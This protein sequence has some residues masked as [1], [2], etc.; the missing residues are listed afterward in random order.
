MV[1]FSDFSNSSQKPTEPSDRTGL[2]DTAVPV[3]PFFG[4]DFT[5]CLCCSWKISD[6]VKQ[7][8]DCLGC[9]AVT[10]KRNKHHIFFIVVHFVKICASHD[11][12]ALE[13]SLKG[14]FVHV[15]YASNIYFVR[16]YSRG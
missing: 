16:K 6:D 11:F 15:T 7:I 1:P 12:I 9:N 8:T 3:P 10:V 2:G 4:C 13:L 14:C 5:P